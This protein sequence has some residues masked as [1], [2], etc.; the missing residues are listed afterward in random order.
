VYKLLCTLALGQV[1]SVQAAV[2]TSISSGVQATVYTSVSSVIQATVY[3]S[4][5][6]GLQPTVRNCRVQ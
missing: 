5:R 3:T 1:Y 4:D 2:Y 6:S